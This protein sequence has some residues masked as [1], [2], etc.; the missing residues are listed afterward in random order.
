MP[1]RLPP[2][3]ASLLSPQ[4]RERIERAMD[5]HDLIRSRALSAIDIGDYWGTPQEEIEKKRAALEAARAV[6]RV[7]AQEYRALGPP[8]REIVRELIEGAVYS[9]GFSHVQRDLLETEFLG[10]PNSWQLDAGGTA[11]IPAAVPESKKTRGIT[12]PFAVAQ[13]REFLDRQDDSWTYEK[14]AEKAHTS[15]DSI[16]NLLAGH[17]MDRKTWAKV[18]HAIG[19]AFNDLFPSTSD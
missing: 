12:S 16:G 6:L 13:V 8:G 1:P 19:R 17:P 7:E 10:R 2:Y 9:N 18:A 4:A 15:V 11:S 5:E 3:P 14:L